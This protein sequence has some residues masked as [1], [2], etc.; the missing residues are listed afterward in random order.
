M[1]RAGSGYTPRMRALVVGA[2]AVGQPYG[3][4]LHLGGAEVT[5]L[6][7]PRHARELEGGM[8][9]Y[10]LNDRRHRTIPVRFRE[11]EL[12]TSAREVAASRWD[13]VYLTVSSTALRGDWL[14]ELLAAVGDATIIALQPGLDDRAL[15]LRHLPE[16]RLVAG[17][18]SLISYAA[19]LPGETRFPEPGVATW[20]PP[21]APSPFSGPSPRVDAV[22][23]ALRAGGFPARRHPD[24]GKLSGFPSALMMPYLVALEASGWTFAGLRAGGHLATAARAAREAM[25]A[26]ATRHGRRPALL[27]L[28]ARP[29]VVRSGLWLGRLVV[30]LDLE[31]YLRVHF[32]KVGDQTR[33]M[34]DR[35]VELAHEHGLEAGALEELR[36]AVPALA[37][38]VVASS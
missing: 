34:M 17:L 25:A 23:A 16:E 33:M 24:V 19:P 28:A 31:T 12:V 7:K 2:G 35:Y 11:Y 38:K 30:P 10:P 13:Q 4:H 27:A 20:F 8:S 29:L 5:F 21:L 6:V 26:V 37:G 9:L 15:I 3:R 1:A 36:A 18:I 32:L 22:V 14:P